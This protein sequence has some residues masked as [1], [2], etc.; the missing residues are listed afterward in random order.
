MSDYA[1]TQGRRSELQPCA[2]ACCLSPLLDLKRQRSRELRQLVSIPSGHLCLEWDLCPASTPI[3]T[4]TRVQF[5]CI[6]V[7]PQLF[8]SF[9]SCWLKKPYCFPSISPS[10]RFSLE[11]GISC[12]HRLGF[13]CFLHR[14]YDQ[15]ILSFKSTKGWKMLLDRDPRRIP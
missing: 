9:Y 1:G 14:C 2:A 10:P 6:Y 7:A 3:S 8:P 5:S 12:W 13:S 11:A 15:N 4:S